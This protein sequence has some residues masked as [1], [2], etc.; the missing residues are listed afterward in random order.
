MENVVRIGKSYFVGDKIGRLANDLLSAREKLK[1]WFPRRAAAG[2]SVSE[3]SRGRQFLRQVSDGIE[4]LD[5]KSVIAYPEVRKACAEALEFSRARGRGVSTQKV[6][7]LKK[8]E[9]LLRNQR[10]FSRAAEYRG[11][12]LCEVAEAVDKGRFAVF[13]TLT[14]ENRH[15]DEVFRQGSNCFRMEMARLKKAVKEAGGEDAYFAYLTIAEEGGETGR[16]HLHQLVIVSDLPKGCSDPNPF[17]GGVN[18]EINAWKRFWRYGHSR[19]IAV[20]WAGDSYG[21]K[22][23]WR[24]PCKKNQDGVLEPIASSGGRLA[25]YLVKY[26]TKQKGERWKRQL[27]TRMTR[28]FGMQKILETVA[29]AETKTLVAV[30]A[31]TRS[32]EFSQVRLVRRVARLEIGRRLLTKAREAT[33]DHQIISR[34]LGT[35]PAQETL[36]QHLSRL[37]LTTKDFTRRN[38]GDWTWV[39]DSE[40]ISKARELLVGLKEYF[41]RCD[42]TTGTILGRG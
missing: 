7:V 42:G 15:Y 21:Q 18:R 38:V 1:A 25:S 12:M 10:E 33:G 24:W 40:G 13:N 35:V 31:W 22:L 37:I 20:R 27:R 36:Y 16:M 4:R 39:P 8:L 30:V 32:L 34:F 3:H 9:E 19:P 26:L 5:N 23:G 28:K 14:V 41:E 11:R 6:E 17:A 29:K 2:V